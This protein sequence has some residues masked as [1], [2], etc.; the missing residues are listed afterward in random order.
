MMTT[1]LEIRSQRDQLSQT[2]LDVLSSWPESHRL[3]FTAVHYAGHRIDVA[4]DLAGIDPDEAARVLE[5]SERRLRAAL[6]AFRREDLVTDGP[7]AP[8][9]AGLH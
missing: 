6:R 9:L 1:G 5:L 8:A 7:E 4:A 2:I 3:V